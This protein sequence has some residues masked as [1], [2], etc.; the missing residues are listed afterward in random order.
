MNRI[1]ICPCGIAKA[2]C[3]YH[4]S[5]Q[6]YRDEIGPVYDVSETKF[7]I[8]VTDFNLSNVNLALG[9]VDFDVC[10]GLSVTMDR[11]I[12]E[13]L[14]SNNLVHRIGN[15][16]YYNKIICRVRKLFPLDSIEAVSKSNFSYNGFRVVSLVTREF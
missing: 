1:E 16:F 14:V 13:K 5:V 10:P 9:A 11:H 7:I 3:D 8:G 2:D 4:S 6:F 15:V 12:Y